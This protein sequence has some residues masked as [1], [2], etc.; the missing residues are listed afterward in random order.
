[1]GVHGYDEFGRLLAHKQL[2]ELIPEPKP[3]H[4]DLLF[5]NVDTLVGAE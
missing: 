4:Q 1:M 3:N 5:A 2:F